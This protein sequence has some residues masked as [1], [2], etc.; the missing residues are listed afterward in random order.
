MHRL[1][2]CFIGFA[3]PL[4]AD[5]SPPIPG[6][7]IEVSRDDKAVYTF[8]LRNDS[9]RTVTYAGYG[10]ENSVQPVYSLEVLDGRTWVEHSPGWCGVGM[11]PCDLP[12]KA[13]LTFPLYRV[14]D[15][16]KATQ[17]FRVSVRFKAGPKSSWDVA[18]EPPIRVHSNEV[19]FTQPQKG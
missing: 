1:L 18:G 13:R 3:V 4:L 6:V 9:D 11:G 7:S 15:V 12:P 10:A 16:A 19:V 17:K 14:G 5:S 2:I 8:V